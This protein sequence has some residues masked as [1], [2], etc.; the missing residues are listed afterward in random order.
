MKN[1]LLLDSRRHNLPSLRVCIS[2]SLYLIFSIS[3]LLCISSPLC[4]FFSVS[5]FALLRHH[6]LCFPHET[7]VRS[8]QDR[9]G[10]WSIRTWRALC[11]CFASVPS[12]PC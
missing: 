3:L 4:L 6:L 12:Y 1:T 9:Q 10:L 11:L 5:L 8:C 2:S 7:A